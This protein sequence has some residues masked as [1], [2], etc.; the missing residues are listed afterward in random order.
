MRPDEVGG[1]NSGSLSIV[2]IKFTVEPVSSPGIVGR[3]E[4]PGNGFEH[5]DRRNSH[6]SALKAFDNRK[7][8]RLR[9][10]RLSIVEV[11]HGK[12]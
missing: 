10:T 7:G 2:C 6:E 12:E 5:P 1:C 9:P 11:G 3:R 4:A 8:I